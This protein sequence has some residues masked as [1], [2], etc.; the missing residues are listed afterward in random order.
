ML[1]TQIQAAEKRVTVQ[2]QK[3]IHYKHISQ[4]LQVYF[5]GNLATEH[6][7]TQRN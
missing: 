7:K 5:K 2:F 6:K 4:I 1:S 3:F